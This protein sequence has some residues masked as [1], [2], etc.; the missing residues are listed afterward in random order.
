M[1]KNLLCSHPLPS[2][3]THYSNTCT[4]LGLHWQSPKRESP[5]FFLQPQM[6]ITFNIVMQLLHAA[7]WQSIMSNIKFELNSWTINYCNE[8]IQSSWS[9]SVIN[10]SCTH[11][12]RHT[13]PGLFDQRLVHRQLPVSV[14]RLQQRLSLLLLHFVLHA[15]GLES[16]KDGDR[17]EGN[18]KCR[19]QWRRHF[20]S[21][22]VTY[23]IFVCEIPFGSLSPQHVSLQL[24]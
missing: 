22:G 17:S 18:D 19:A 9:V 5:C 14:H 7:N 6:M 24:I 3:H 16:L 10:Y 8:L 15:E 12:G 13:V 11:P 1:N 4:P 23:L 2:E 20:G 21:S